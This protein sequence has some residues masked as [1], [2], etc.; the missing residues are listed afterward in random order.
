MVVFCVDCFDWL[1]VLLPLLLLRG[2]LVMAVVVCFCV[3]VLF[4]G[5]VAVDD[6]DI[7]LDDFL[8]VMLFDFGVDS[9]SPP[10]IVVCSMDV[11]IEVT[12]I[13]CLVLSLPIVSAAILVWPI[14]IAPSCPKKCF[15]HH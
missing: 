14:D 9:R 10:S 1:V 11:S 8:G 5:Y 12:I 7:L 6:D 3:L 4:V 2:L 15:Q 13:S